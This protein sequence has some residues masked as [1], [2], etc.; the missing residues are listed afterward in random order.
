MQLRSYRPIALQVLA[1]SAVVAAAA[2]DRGSEGNTVNPRPDNGFSETERVGDRGT[3][4]G[5]FFDRGG[6]QA[7]PSSM[8]NVP[9]SD[10]GVDRGTAKA[11]EAAGAGSPSS[12]ERPE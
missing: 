8:S 3:H 11:V 12:T 6:R 7:D 5:G 1:L 9:N 4:K 2:C 10:A